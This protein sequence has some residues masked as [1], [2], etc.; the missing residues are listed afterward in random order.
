MKML[1]LPSQDAHCSENSIAGAEPPDRPVLE[2]ES[3]PN[4]APA[5]RPPSPAPKF[6]KA[7]KCDAK[8]RLAVCGPSGSGKTYTL[9]KLATELGGP[10][11]VVDTERGSAS[12]YADLFEFDVME[13]GSYNP[14]DLIKIIDAA[15][16]AGYRVLC[17]D[18]LSHFW[19]GK[20]GELDQVD[21]AA[22]RMQTPNSFAAWKHVTPIHNQL[23]DKI[24]SAPIH[25]L[26]SL[27]SKT[28]WVLDRDDRT[29]KTV[30][31]KVGLAPVMRDGI[32]YEFDVCGDMD[33]ENTLL[34]TKTRC[35]K[36]AG[37]IFPKPGK[38]LA[39]VLKEW[40][41][42][43]VLQDHEAQPSKPGPVTWVEPPAGGLANGVDG[44]QTKSVIPQ[45]L[46]SIWKR[47]CTPR[48]VNKELDDLKKSIEQLAG[49][50]GVAE[51]QRILRQH[52]VGHT[53]QFK[54]SEPARMCAKDVFGLLEEL[55]RN[56][57]DNQGALPAATGGECVVRESTAAPEAR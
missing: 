19:M 22:R 28:E 12:K 29:G 31:R 43:V 49:S 24:T 41:Q 11:A 38:E 52:S 2:N 35:S 14:L 54:S 30:P 33:Q 6:R 23:V 21:R 7:T 46:A 48:G 5:P 18:S 9:L 37:S 3:K 15:A 47:M 45:Q 40:L 17:I 34:I 36:L 1:W 51:Y 42:G 39:D 26:V 56:A 57:R 25:V 53:N 4:G 20:D 44:L 55:R 8:L 50:T 27:R 16:Q 10:I 32:E 13:L